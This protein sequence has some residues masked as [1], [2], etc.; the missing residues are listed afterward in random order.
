MVLAASASFSIAAI[1]AVG[2]SAASLPADAGP[3]SDLAS[4]SIRPTIVSIFL[5]LASGSRS[6]PPNTAGQRATTAANALAKRSSSA[7][8]RSRSTPRAASS[9]C[10]RPRSARTLA[11]RSA[12][13]SA[14]AAD[15][16]SPIADSVTPADDGSTDD[17]SIDDGSAGDS[18]LTT[19]DSG[20]PT[21][22]SGLATDD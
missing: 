22:D 12:G 8:A 19:G 5:R 7:T 3:A 20:L 13:G 9:V 4:V 6:E 17:S 2:D 21:D 14:G 1:R 15:C 18:A 16:E 11:I 10:Q